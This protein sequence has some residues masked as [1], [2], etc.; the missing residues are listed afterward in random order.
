MINKYIDNEGMLCIFK[1][2]SICKTDVLCRINSIS[3]V[4]NRECNKKHKLFKLQKHK[5]G[6]ENAE[7]KI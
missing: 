5:G 1:R 7:E 6:I 3:E 2:C 4:H